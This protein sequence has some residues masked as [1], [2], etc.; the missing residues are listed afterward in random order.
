MSLGYSDE[1]F[2]PEG[3]IKKPSVPFSFALTDILPDLKA[4][5]LVVFDFFEYLITSVLSLL[6]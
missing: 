2:L 1:Y 5:R 4:D 3:V 6:T